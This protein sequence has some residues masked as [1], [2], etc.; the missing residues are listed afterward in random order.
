MLDKNYTKYFVTLNSDGSSEGKGAPVF[1]IFVVVHF[2]NAIIN[3]GCSIVNKYYMW[4]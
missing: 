1:H 2:L 3:G 4:D